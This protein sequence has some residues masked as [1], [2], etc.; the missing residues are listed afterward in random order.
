MLGY[1]PCFL[2]KKAYDEWRVLY[3]ELGLRAPAGE[4]FCFDC[5]PERQKEAIDK[6]LCTHP[7]VVFVEL[8]D[9]DGESFTAGLRPWWLL[10]KD[11][12]E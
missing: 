3:D 2:S 8:V 12:T 6:G 11:A 4:S 9:E 10:E 1:P 7:D 5:L